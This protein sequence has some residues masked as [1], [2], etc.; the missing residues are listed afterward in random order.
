MSF[1]RFAQYSFFRVYCAWEEFEDLSDD[2][3][4]VTTESTLIRGV[5]EYTGGESIQLIVFLLPL[6]PSRPVCVVIGPSL[7]A[8]RRKGLFQSGVYSK[9]VTS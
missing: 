9:K 5:Y 4:S 8:L 3:Q 1:L 6:P 7:S 2:E